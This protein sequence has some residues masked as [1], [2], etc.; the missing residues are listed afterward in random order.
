MSGSE[1]V[2]IMFVIQNTEDIYL[3]VYN[4]Y[5]PHVFMAVKH[6]V[7]EVMVKL[8]LCL[9]KYH[10]IKMYKEES[11]SNLSIF[12]INRIC[13]NRIENTSSLF[14]IVPTTFNAGVPALH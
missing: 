1:T 10:T 3:H 7:F 4:K 12:F 9:T 11:K 5:I 13:T 2:V 8:S 14:N 6:N